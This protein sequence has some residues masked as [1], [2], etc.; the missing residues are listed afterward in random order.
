[1]VQVQ[2]I[3]GYLAPLPLRLPLL[4]AGGETGWMAALSAGAGAG[5]DP[6]VPSGGWGC[7]SGIEAIWIHPN[8]YV[9][10]LPGRSK[11]KQPNPWKGRKLPARAGSCGYVPSS[12][13]SPSAAKPDTA[14]T[15]DA[16]KA[17]CLETVATTGC[18]GFLVT[19]GDFPLDDYERQPPSA[20]T[21][22]CKHVDG[23]K[24]MP[25]LRCTLRK[26]PERFDKLNGDKPSTQTVSCLMLCK[27]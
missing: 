8:R 10:L 27:L 11:E 25:K 24:I 17:F 3:E 21:A 7:G 23:F 13:V 14:D 22:W 12:P 4:G 19:Y 9:P 26:G 5:A 2:V 18:G 20:V 6:G 16:S 1:M 15:N